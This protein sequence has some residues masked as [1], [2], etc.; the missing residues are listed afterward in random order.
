MTNATQ[1]YAAF[2]QD[3]L[4]AAKTHRWSIIAGKMPRQGQPWYRVCFAD[5]SMLVKIGGIWIPT[6]GGES[7]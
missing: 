5:G 3:P 1:A 6:M 7:C 2:M 4:E